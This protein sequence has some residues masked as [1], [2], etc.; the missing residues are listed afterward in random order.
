MVAYAMTCHLIKLKGSVLPNCHQQSS[1][2][3]GVGAKRQLKICLYHHPHC[4]L[5]CDYHY[6][7]QQF[8]LLLCALSPSA[9]HSHCC[10]H[11]CLFFLCVLSPPPVHFPFPLPPP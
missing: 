9:S 7:H 6:Y 4:L 2:L 10:H 5:S 3:L 8:C 1:S 11:C